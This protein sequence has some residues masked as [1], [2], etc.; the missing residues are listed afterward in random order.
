MTAWR[1]IAAL[2]L[3]LGAFPGAADI[4]GRVVEVQDATQ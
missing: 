4:S 2:A 1:L 3:L